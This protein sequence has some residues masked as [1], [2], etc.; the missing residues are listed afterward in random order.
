[1]GLLKCYNL[2]IGFDELEDEKT[3]VPEPLICNQKI[4]TIELNASAEA[5]VVRLRNSSGSSGHV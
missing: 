1:M 3:P 5:F 2:G 4:L